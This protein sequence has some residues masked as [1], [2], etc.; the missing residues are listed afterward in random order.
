MDTVWFE[1]YPFS[2]F[3]QWKRMYIL[4]TLQQTFGP[5]QDYFDESQ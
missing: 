2:Y 3:F 1:Y 4:K 5:G